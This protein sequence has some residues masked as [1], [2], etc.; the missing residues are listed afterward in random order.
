MAGKSHRSKS[1]TNVQQ[2]E[3]NKGGCISTKACTLRWIGC[4]LLLFSSLLANPTGISVYYQ[5]NYLTFNSTKT[6][7]SFLILGH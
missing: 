4:C 2:R 7:V 6:F 3:T 5:I 1:A